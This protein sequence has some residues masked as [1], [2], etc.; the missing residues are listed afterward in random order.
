M[1]E[2]AILAI[3]RQRGVDQ[4]GV[5]VFQMVIADAQLVGGAGFEIFDQYIG[6]G[7]QGFEGLQTRWIFQIDSDRFLGAVLG[8]EGQG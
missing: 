3:G 5:R 4:G 6:A 7:D 2:R 1:A 8:H